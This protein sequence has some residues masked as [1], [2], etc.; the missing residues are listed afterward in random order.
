[1]PRGTPIVAIADMKVISIKDNSAEQKS[2]KSS[3]SLNKKHGEDH[4]QS[5][6]IMKPFDDVK[7]FFDLLKFI[8]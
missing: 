7:M 6:K 8:L 4:Y 2:G 1:M 3:N 5:A